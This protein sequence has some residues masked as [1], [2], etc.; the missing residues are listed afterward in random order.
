MLS[1]HE[2]RVRDDVQRFWAE[3][4]SKPPRVEPG[5]PSC[6]EPA[7]RDLE[8]LPAWAVAGAWVTVLLVLFGAAVAGL[9]VGVATALGWALWH[10]W[11]LL[12]RQGAPDPLPTPGKD[13]TTRELVDEP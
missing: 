11:P 5:A 4:V 9:P 13:T 8:H 6:S 1:R 2:Q 10:R 7:P 3:E 12:S